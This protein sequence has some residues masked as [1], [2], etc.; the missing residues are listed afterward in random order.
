[1]IAEFPKI[2][3]TNH[4]QLKS[5]VTLIILDNIGLIP[6]NKIDAVFNNSCSNEVIAPYRALNLD[7]KSI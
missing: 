7:L 1:M 5:S 6:Q 3:D 2:D 4:S